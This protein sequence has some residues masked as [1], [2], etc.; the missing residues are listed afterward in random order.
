M[1]IVIALLVCSGCASLVQ[2]DIYSNYGGTAN[3][4]AVGLSTG[5]VNSGGASAPA[6][7]SWS[8]V[9]SSLGS[10]LGSLCSPG[11]E[12]FPGSG[13]PLVG[14]VADDF[15]VPAG[16][17]WDVTRLSVFA[18]RAGFPANPSP[19]A[20]GTMTLWSG[21]PESGG[22]AVIATG[23][24]GGASDT[25]IYRISHGGAD[26][27]RLVRQV[28]FT[29]SGVTLTAGT[30]WMEYQ[31]F[32]TDGGPLIVPPITVV[33]PGGPDNCVTGSPSEIQETF[34]SIPFSRP[35][36]SIIDPNTSLAYD[37]PFIVDGSVV[38][39]PSASV[40]L[41]VACVAAMARRRR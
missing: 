36:R 6:G 1:K 23:T 16:V 25:S 27:D 28:D 39:A 8:E 35:W 24:F 22:S 4:S 17:S 2:A 21:H 7:S 32:S 18:Y 5:P 30:Y 29:F 3:P 12:A 19:V 33:Q 31:L 34:P 37:L 9:Q 41:G 20:S 14:R 13:I 15:S 38:P 10:L 40:G 26:L 11:A